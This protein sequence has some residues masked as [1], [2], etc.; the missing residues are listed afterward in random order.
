MEQN[1][2]SN[3]DLDSLSDKLNIVIRCI[4]KFLRSIQKRKESPHP[5]EGGRYEPERERQQLA[6]KFKTST[7]HAMVGDNKWQK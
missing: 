2:D 4:E 6:K 7:Q 1:L 5:S 3:Q